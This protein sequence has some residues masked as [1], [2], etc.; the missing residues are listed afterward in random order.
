MHQSLDPE[1]VTA[2]GAPAVAE[3]PQATRMGPVHLSVSDLGRSID[4]YRHAVGLHLQLEDGLQATLGA[5]DSPLLVLTEEPGAVPS[6]GYCGLYHF[7]LLVPARVD[8]ARWLA[9][10][11]ANNLDLTGMADHFVS[12][13]LYLSDPDDHGI[14]VY[15]D[16]PREFWEGGVARHMTTMR[17]QVDDL[18]MELDDEKPAPYAGLPAGTTMGHVHLQVATVACSVAFYRDILGFGLMA[19]LGNHAAFLSAGG[20]HHHLGANTWESAGNP[21]APPGTA[22][23]LQVNI[24][25]PSAA[26]VEK[27]ADRVAATGQKPVHVDGAVLVHDPSGNPVALRSEDQV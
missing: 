27:L 17:L 15:W 10:A 9:H 19:S 12:E 5:G 18:I 1:E 26:D 25:M 24:V 21:P 2:T 14:E 4:Y 8:L 20:Y 22:R 7:A 16:R 23:L 3:V 6:T 11:A 13:A